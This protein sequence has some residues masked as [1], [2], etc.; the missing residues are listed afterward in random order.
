[1]LFQCWATI[2]GAWLNINSASA[3]R[4]VFDVGSCTRHYH[5]A[6][7]AGCATLFRYIESVDDAGHH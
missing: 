1:M 4:I 7:D 2:C 3:Q 6:L 5:T